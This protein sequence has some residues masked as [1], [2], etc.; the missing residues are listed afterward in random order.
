MDSILEKIT[1]YDILGY[2][3]PGS[4]FLL[5]LF[6]G[7]N[8]VEEDALELMAQW[9]G[10]MAVLYLAFII[11]AY[12]AGVMLSEVSE[13]IQWILGKLAAAFRKIIWTRLQH[14]RRMQWFVNMCRPWMDNGFGYF[15]GQIAKALVRSGIDKSEA[16]VIADI[17]NGK[18]LYY[19]KY[20]YGNIQGS[21]D[22]KRIHS[23]A[24]AYIMY[25]NTASAL[26]FGVFLLWSVYGIRSGFC[27]GMLWLGVLLAVRSIRFMKKKKRYALIW[28][29]EKYSEGNTR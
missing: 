27:H 26:L 19:K 28:F 4:A 21:S 5:L 6:C 22:Y 24:S 1:L 25:R 29:M 10:N 18:E 3:F 17:Q 8:T 2:F 7:R 23:Y 16:A 14:V 20:I 9:N 13:W 11:A 15:E 12:L